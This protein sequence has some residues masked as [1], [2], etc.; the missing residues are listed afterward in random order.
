MIGP[1]LTQEVALHLESSPQ[2]DSPSFSVVIPV[3]RG[4]K[5]PPTVGC[6][7]P[8]LAKAAALL[9]CVSLTY[10]LL[11][12]GIAIRRASWRPSRLLSSDLDE[13]CAGSVSQDQEAWQL[14]VQLYQFSASR[15]MVV[16]YF[17]PLSLIIRREA[18]TQR[19]E[20]LPHLQLRS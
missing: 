18:V 20:K 9:A 4:F 2:D 16:L 13:A 6:V 8:Y 12:C 1:A 14:Q 3:K 15:M 17:C 11:S 19:K 10:L 7:L 5:K